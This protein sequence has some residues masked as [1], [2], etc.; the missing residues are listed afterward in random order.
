[1]NMGDLHERK[2]NLGSK[3]QK[4][5]MIPGGKKDIRYFILIV[6]IHQTTRKASHNRIN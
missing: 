2:G 6:K 1:M 4:K 5:C 3:K